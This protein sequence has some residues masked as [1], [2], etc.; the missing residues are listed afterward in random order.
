MDSIFSPAGAIVF[1]LALG[2]FGI[3]F[4]EASRKRHKTSDLIIGLVM[5]L[6]LVALT[7]W[8]IFILVFGSF[9]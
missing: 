5:L 2:L 4:I 1:S 6:P 3:Y 8:T 9:E 7:V